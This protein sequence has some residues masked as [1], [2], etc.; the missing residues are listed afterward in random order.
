MSPARNVTVHGQARGTDPISRANGVSESNRVDGTYLFLLSIPDRSFAICDHIAFHQCGSA[1]RSEIVGFCILLLTVPLQGTQLFFVAT[2]GSR[3]TRQPRAMR[4]NS[5]GV[6]QGG[7]P[8]ERPSGRLMGVRNRCLSRPGLRPKRLQPRPPHLEK[9]D[10][11]GPRPVN[12][13]E[14]FEKCDN[15]SFQSSVHGS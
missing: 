10:G 13:Y 3:E 7:R 5:F 14:I 2:R 11:P 6:Q 1:R 15:I 8:M 12:G 9:G 4:R